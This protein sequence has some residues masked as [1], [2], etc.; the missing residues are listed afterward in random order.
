MK[1]AEIFLTGAAEKLDLKILAYRK[2][3]VNPAG[4]GPTAL[5]VEP[6]N[7]TGFYCAA[8]IISLIQMNLK[9]NLFVLRNYA[10]IS[11]TIR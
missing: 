8:P 10:A 1:N 6:R 11:S 9:E 3:P 4:I 7:G 5:S 2:V